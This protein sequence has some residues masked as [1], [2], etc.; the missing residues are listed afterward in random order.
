MRVV[1]IMHRPVKTVAPD[2]PLETARATM[3]L[4]DVR[5][6]VVTESGGIVGV[7]SDRDLGGKRA[8]TLPANGVVEGRMARDVVT[9]TPETTVREA[10]N[11][12][13]GHR[14]GCLPVLDERGKLVGIV[15]ETDLLELLGRGAESPFVR[16]ERGTLARRASHKATKRAGAR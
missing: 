14:I 7:L 8:A 10:A 9:A 5:H 1:E 15:T 4:H 2:T 3:E 11:L 16:K 13:R 12:M 6:L